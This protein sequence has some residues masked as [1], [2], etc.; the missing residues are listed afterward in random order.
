MCLECKESTGSKGPTGR[1]CLKS[2]GKMPRERCQGRCQAG[3]STG[4]KE[5]QG[6]TFRV[7]REHHVGVLHARF[8]G[9]NFRVVGMG[10]DM[11]LQILG[12]LES[13]ATEVALVRLERHMDPD[14]RGYVVTLDGGSVAST[15]L[16]SQVQVV[17]ALASNMALADVFL[18]SRRVSIY[19]T[20][21]P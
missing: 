14:V 11:L 5:S 15:P 21:S 12:T 10:L 19:S 1:H 2:K 4:G 6:R 8:G 20:L 16:A 3:S 17:S 7:L 9:P 13:L 18:R